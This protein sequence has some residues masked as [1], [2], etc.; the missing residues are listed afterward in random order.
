[1]PSPAPLPGYA[2]LH[3]LSNFS[4]QRGASHPKELVARAAQLGYQAL[5]LTDECSVA[6]VVR[7]WE[8]AKECGLHLIVGSEFVWGDLRLVALARDAQGWGNLCEFI[9]AARA[10]A[11]KGQYHVGPGSPFSLLQ[12][13]ELLLAPCRERMGASDFVAVS[14]CLSS[15]RAQFGLNFDGHLWLAVELHLAPD[16]SLWLA[17]LQRAGAALGLPLVAA[18]DV[19]MHARSRKPLQDVI[20]AVQRG[21][22]VAECGFALQPNAERHLRQRVRLAGIYPPELLAATLTVAARCT[23]SL[24]EIRYQYPLETVPS[25]MT[26]AQALAWLA[27]EGAMGRYPQGV[28]DWIAAQIRKELALIAHCQY[29]MYFLTVHDIVRFARSQGILCQGRGSAANSVVCYVL[30]IT[31]VAPEDSHLLFERFIS[32]ERSEPPDIDVDFEHDRREEVIQYIYAKYGRER[33]AI[34]AVVATYR[35]RSALRDVGKALAVAPA[36]VDAFAKD[37]HWFDEGIAADRLQELAKGLGVPLH[38]HTA[39]LWLELAAQLKGFPRHLSQHVGGFVLTQGKLTRLVPVEPASMEGRS[40]IQWDK[41][42]LDT[43]GLLKVDV[44]ALGMLSALRRC[45]QLRAVLRGEPW[46]LADIPREDAATY[47]M[48]C[49]ADTVGVFQI[50]SRAQMSMLPRLQPRVFYDLVVQVAIVRP[51][52]IQGGMVHPYLQARERRRHGQPL[53]LEKPEL[54]AALARTLGVPIFQEQVMQIAMIAAGF[55]PGMADDLRRSMAAWKRKGGVHRFERPL[56]GGMEARGY[57]T[58]FAQ[59]IFQQMLGFGEYGFPESHA[60]SFALL[61]YASSWLKCHEPA[62]FLAALLNSLPMGFYS[63]SQL[64]QD[65][66]RHGVRVLPIDVLASHWDCT[67]EGPLAAVPGVAL[68]QPAVRLGLRL[69]SGLAT[70]AGQRLVQIRQAL[71]DAAVAG[72]PGAAPAPALAPEFVP[73]TCFTSTEDLALRAQLSQQDLQALAAADA[74]ASLSG[75]RRQQMWDA[76]AQHT[77]PALWRDVP[78]HEVP[79]ALPA[80]HE[81]EE[82][83][84]DYAATG[85]TLRRHPLALLRP[86]LARWRLQTALQLHSAPNGRK[87]R[88]CGIVTMR[89]RPGTAKGTMFVTLEDE[90]GPVNVI[91]WPAL[92]EHWRQPLLGARLLA[93]E[94]VWQCSPH[95]PDGQAVVRHLVA[96]RFKDLTPLLGRMAQALQGSRDF[97]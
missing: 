70:A 12:G 38:R 14:A 54:E 1:M 31:A 53:E 78:V 69:V 20:T 77:A 58:E 83:V 37:H 66:R 79:L 17:T 93:V 18:G 89:Q 63:A 15:A 73:A 85:L 6:G 40:V 49:A 61:S 39:A 27:Q 47:D 62:C 7:A 86:R 11:P 45:L 92:V 75:H 3:C 76:A 87:V 72:K 4:F 56:I 8:A 36:L 52:P 51:G 82:I 74:L 96:Q 13:C 29:E 68:P 16:D 95:G 22:S 46:G 59:A 33:A 2:E 21:C 48:I 94:G 81:G 80:A 88:A 42:D 84:F 97:H 23:F 67:L 55:G 25:G 32:K 5:A 9:T 65:A 60:H 50:E 64:V 24:G 10:A 26:P 41:D 44:L 57:R 35:T 34:T 91:V 30:G 71:H 90:T 19:H 28:P 43:M